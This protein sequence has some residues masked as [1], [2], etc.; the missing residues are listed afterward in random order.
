MFLTRDRFGAVGDGV[1][2]DTAALQKAIDAVQETTGEGIVFVP[3]GRYRLSATLYVWPGIRVIGY[4]ARR[5]RSC[6]ARTP[7]FQDPAQPRYMVFFAGRRPKDGAP[8]PDANPG[9][10]YS[11]LSNVD[12][13]IGDGN[14]GAVGVRG[15]LRAALLHVPRRVPHRLGPRRHPRRRQRGRGRELRGRRLRHLDR[16]AVAGLAADA[17]RRDASRAS[18]RRRSAS[19]RP[20]SR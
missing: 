5:R 20:A 2:D 18:A 12:L 9:T 13:E 11:A 1:A 7:G 14:P 10:F 16:H 3:E 19:R 8:P 17:R 15:A 4:G 6:S